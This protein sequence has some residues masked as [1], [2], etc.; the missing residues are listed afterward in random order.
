[1]TFV[2]ALFPSV[3]LFSFFFFVEFPCICCSQLCRFPSYFSKCFRV[4]FRFPVMWVRISVVSF[5]VSFAFHVAIRCVDFVFRCLCFFVFFLSTNVFFE[6]A[7]QVE[8]RTGWILECKQ[9][10]CHTSTARVN[11]PGKQHWGKRAGGK[12]HE[13]TSLGGNICPKKNTPC[14]KTRRRKQQ[15][16]QVA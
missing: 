5:R 16:K 3:V 9:T 1:M 14:V 12:Q 4:L 2:F 15:G 10:N 8:K 13:H 7:G 6:F 11:S